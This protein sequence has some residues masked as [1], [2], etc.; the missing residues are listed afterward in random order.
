MKKSKFSLSKIFY[1]DKFVMLFSVVTALVLWVFVS[2]NSTG[3]KRELSIS[4]I[5][6]EIEL[7]E[8][9]KEAGLEVFEG[10]EATGSVRIRGNVLVVG[11]AGA[12]N[13]KATA[14]TASITAPG[15]YTLELVYEKIGNLDFEI[16]AQS[17]QFLNVYVDRLREKSFTID[18][19]G[20]QR[21]ID[22]DHYASTAELSL[23]EITVSGPETLMDNISNVVAECSF[24]GELTETQTQI[25][26]LVL[27]DKYGDIIQS[28]QLTM[29]ANEIEVTLPVY[30]R[31]EIKLKPDFS[32]KPGGFDLARV[33]IDPESLEIAASGD[34]FKGFSTISL[35]QI[36]FSKINTRS[37]KL[38]DLEILIPTGCKNLSNTY[39]ASL[40]I[41]MTGID[42]KTLL[43][44]NFSVLNLPADKISNVATQ[45]LEV[46]ING[47]SEELEKLTKEDL[48][49]EIDMK[50]KENLTG[51]T[52]VPVT[53]RIKNAS[54]CWA[55]GE[56]TANISIDSKEE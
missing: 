6:V 1:N 32:G 45:S 33:S 56:Y 21:I 11:V 40:T 35:E 38:D 16:V 29:S 37:R 4:N 48:V 53:I 28:D 30:Q 17:P 10:K 55:Y 19:G 54:G 15:N 5:P 7:G 2:I 44:T 52:E 8:S 36:A 13:I 14:K 43:V 3:S 51:H 42:Y 18:D 20:I 25:A 39:R 31:K 34:V 12:E 47:P 41:D 27:Y 46:E 24:E 49:A 26:R 22:P 23:K 9:A 50:G